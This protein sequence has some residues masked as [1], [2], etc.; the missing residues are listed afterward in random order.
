MAGRR[1]GLRKMR[2]SQSIDPVSTQT[3]K[4]WLT[5]IL[6]KITKNYNHLSLRLAHNAIATASFFFQIFP[7]AVAV[8]IG[9]FAN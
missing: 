6:S 2:F 1:V 7:Y 3:K 5:K 9:F 8:T 4:D